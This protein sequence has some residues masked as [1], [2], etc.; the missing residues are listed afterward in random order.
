GRSLGGPREPHRRG[1]RDRPA[2]AR[3]RVDTAA[4]AVSRRIAPAVWIAAALLGMTAFLTIVTEG[5]VVT[6]LS[7]YPTA[8]AALADAT[9]GLTAMTYGI[10]GALILSRRANAVGAILLAFGLLGAALGAS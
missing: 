4:G 7:T 9:D 3:E 1:G 6:G 2:G 8:S 5:L 10:V